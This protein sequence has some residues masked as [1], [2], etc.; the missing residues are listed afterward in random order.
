M[1]VEVER[2]TPVKIA[3]AVV[4]HCVTTFSGL[5]LVISRIKAICTSLREAVGLLREA[6]DAANNLSTPT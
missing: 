4:E 5:R 2:P 1:E 3:L 6:T